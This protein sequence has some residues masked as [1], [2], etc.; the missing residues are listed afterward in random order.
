MRLRF[1]L[2]ALALAVV[3]LG[4]QAQIGLYLNPVA[5]RISVS[6]ADTGP[7]AFLG[8]NTTSRFFGGVAMGGYY[9]FVHR[10][11]LD[12]GA[13]IRDTLVHGN[14]ASLNTFMVAARVTRPMKYR[15][16]P[17]VQLGIGAGS[18][19]AEHTDVRTLKAEWGVFVGADYALNKHVDFRAIELGYGSVTPASSAIY[20]PQLPLPTATLINI[21]S[22]FVFRFGK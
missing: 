17:Y 13:D 8:D 1:V 5:T 22:G 12:F 14:N 7:F 4:A 15:L 18:S 2:P 20:N 16:R 21:S 3:T 10:P 9:D 6:Q 19:K 11:G